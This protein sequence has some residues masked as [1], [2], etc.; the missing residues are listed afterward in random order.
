MV[1]F[2]NRVNDIRKYK[3]LAVYPFHQELS[4]RP[5]DRS[6][7]IYNGIMGIKDKVKSFQNVKSR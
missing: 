1:R 4:T 7:H 2:G 6:V 3:E 5:V